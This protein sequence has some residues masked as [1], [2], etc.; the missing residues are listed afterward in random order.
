MTHVAN[1]PLGQ[2]ADFIRG[3]TFKPVDLVDPFS[4]E[5]VVCMRTKNIQIDLDERDLI[6]VPKRF[7]PREDKYL[8]EGDILISSANSWNL[9]GKC[10][11]VPRLR[12]EATAGGFISILRAK[13]GYDPRFLYHW[14]NSPRVQHQARHCGRQTTNI[15]NLDVNRFLNLHVP[16]QDLSQQRL[17]ARVLDKAYDIC[18]KTAQATK[19]ANK[20]LRA[21]F[22]DMFGDPQ[23][24]SKRLPMAPIRQLGRVVTGNTPPRNRPDYYGRGI[25]WVKSDNLGAA[26]HYVTQ[27]AEQLSTQGR[28]VARLVPIGSTLVT[29]IAG[30]SNSIGNA[31]I[32][33]REV[34]F[35]QQINA[36]IPAREVDPAFLYCQFLVGKALIQQASTNSMKGMVSKSKFEEIMFLNPPFPDQ[37]RFGR[38]FMHVRGHLQY[39]RLA[40][41]ESKKMFACL[42]QRAFAGEL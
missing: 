18:L 2:A 41:D 17:A 42:S 6:A 33:D 28:S 34:A 21:V 22:L 24:N 14:L 15:A 19:L 32:A 27:A 8:R 23:T 10:C 1:V 39:L 7:V 20:F 29:C 31:A 30:S 3:I 4:D 13:P 12:Y 11:Y 40:S 26:D 16:D 5:S 37:S 9:V 25:E 35:N 36:V 38:V